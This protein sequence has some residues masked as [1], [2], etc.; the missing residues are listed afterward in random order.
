MHKQNTRTT[1]AVEAY[2]GVLNKLVEK[3][4]N[5]FKFVQ[6]IRS[7]EFAKSRHFAILVASGGSASKKKR[8]GNKEQIISEATKLLEHAKITV[9]TFLNRMVYKD[10]EI[11]TDMLPKIDVNDIES[12]SHTIEEESPDEEPLPEIGNDRFC[13]ICQDRYPNIVLLPCKHLILCDEC[14]LKVQAGAVAD[15]S[16]AYNCPCCR[17]KVEDTL[18]I[19][20]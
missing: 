16:N 19:Y 13:V 18:Q 1:S 6:A 9:G 12:N 15:N 10:N 14:H 20:S 2:N 5:F 3:N 17:V 8:R 4:G 7:E 11:C